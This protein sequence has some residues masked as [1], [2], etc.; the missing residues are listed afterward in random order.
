MYYNGEGVLRSYSEAASWYTKA[1]LQGHS[2]AQLFLGLMY[3]HGQGVN[4]SYTTAAKWV[5]KSYDNNYPDAEGVWNNYE[6]WK[7]E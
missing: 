1:A 5:K 2:A 6:L 3:I 4:Q 7:Y